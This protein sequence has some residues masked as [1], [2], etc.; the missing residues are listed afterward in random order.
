MLHQEFAPPPPLQDAVK[1]F[2]Y[3]KRDA[4]IDLDY[5]EVQPDGYAEIIFYFGS[6][7][8][9]V[10][11]GIIQPLPSPFMI[12]LLHQPVIF[13]APG[14]LEI[15]AIRCYPWAVFNLLGIAS[16]SDSV[17]RFQHP[18]S[19]LHAVIER[20]IKD[21]NVEGA[22]LSVT[23]FFLKERPQSFEN[24]MLI[25]AGN[26]MRKAKGNVMVGEV[27]NAAHATIRTLER[28]F[29]KSSGHTVK[30]VAAL[31]R[32][33]QARN[34]LWTQPIVNLA[35]LAHE[36]GYSD[37]PHLSRDFKRYSGS[38]PAAFARNAKHNRLILETDFVAFVQD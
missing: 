17:Q 5:I 35:A 8:S 28:N 20:F 29:K 11:K 33:E 13:Y 12:G 24:S 37:Q 21:G 23:E 16:G 36:L 9:I 2:W 4:G 15:I 25:K 26:T 18:I 38:S 30:E 34:R 31:M 22:I 7:C 3:N 19:R 32:F 1:C 6:T 14:K 10:K 27:A